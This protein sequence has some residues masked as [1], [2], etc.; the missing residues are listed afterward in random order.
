M[1]LVVSRNQSGVSLFPRRNRRRADKWA[2]DVPGHGADETRQ[3][4]ID[5][6][7]STSS[8][9]SPPQVIFEGTT[10]RCHHPNADVYQAQGWQIT[11]SLLTGKPNCVLV[12]LK[13][14]SFFSIN[15]QCT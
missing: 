11:E 3:I 5:F 8:K 4:T 1:D 15:H 14:L 6:A 12:S 2:K 7:I 9:I 13:Y 10:E